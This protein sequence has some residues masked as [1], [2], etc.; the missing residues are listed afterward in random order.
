M[1][2]SQRCIWNANESRDAWEQASW[3]AGS[4]EAE[5]NQFEGS[6]ADEEKEEAVNLAGTQ[7]NVALASEKNARRMVAKA[8]AIMHEIKSSLGGYCPQGANKKG[9]GAGKG[10]SKGQGK[11]RHSHGRAPGQSPTASTSQAG[12]RP[13]KPMLPPRRPCLKC[14]SRDHE[15][16]KCPKTMFDCGATDTVGTVEAIEA[17]VDKSQEV[18]GTAHDWVSVD[19]NDRPVHNF[20]VAKRKQALSK[21]KVQVQPG[22]HVT[23]LLALLSAKSL[24]AL[25]AVINFETG[26]AIFRNLEPEAVVQLERSPTGH[27]WI[28]LFQHMPVVCDNLLSLLGP[29]KLGANVGLMSRN[30]KAHVLVAHT[31]ILVLIPNAHPLLGRRTRLT[32]MTRRR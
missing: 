5:D 31:V 13:H 19:I 10:K 16:G 4:W 18:F 24:T 14:G 3:E 2:G 20:G 28:D 27:L 12:T 9:S 7:L 26:H 32:F 30:S 22:G 15:S 8:R 21:V 29:V 17:P 6:F 11:N 25:R 1:S 23:H